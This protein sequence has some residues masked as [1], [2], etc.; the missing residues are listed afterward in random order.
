VGKPLIN[1]SDNE[2]GFTTLILLKDNMKI[3]LL[4]R[5]GIFQKKGM[6]KSEL[7]SC[8]EQIIVYRKHGNKKREKSKEFF[9]MPP[10]LGV[11]EN[12]VPPH[13]GWFIS[14]FPTKVDNR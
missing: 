10:H 3:A 2:I 14:I 12:S 13:I 11:S 7:R 8:E 1:H 4:S 6:K 5:F 9:S